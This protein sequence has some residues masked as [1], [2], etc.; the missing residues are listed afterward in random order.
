MIDT[1]TSDI[2]IVKQDVAHLETTLKIVMDNSPTQ[3]IIVDAYRNIHANKAFLNFFGFDSLEAFLE[4]RECIASYFIKGEAPFESE[5]NTIKRINHFEYIEQLDRENRLILIE[6][7]TSRV[8]HIMQIKVD[9][10]PNDRKLLSLIDISELEKEASEQNYLLSH[11]RLTGIHNRHYFEELFHHTHALAQREGKTL[12]LILFDVDD[13]KKVNDTYGHLKG[14]KVLKTLAQKVV[15]LIR[16]SDTFARWGGE[17]FIL[18]LPQTDIEEASILASKLREAIR[19]LTI[20]G[21]VQVTS[22]FGLASSLPS[23]TLETLFA[24]ADKA[25]YRAKENGKD[26]IEGTIPV[27]RRHA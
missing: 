21:I 3:M 27:K 22:S 11:D 14:D 1:L 16:K 23:D 7:K 4:R 18:M 10:L 9:E 19:N 24:R 15:N 12:S 6:N 26:C 5:H 2:D 17:E 8:N 25:L 20:D 13:F